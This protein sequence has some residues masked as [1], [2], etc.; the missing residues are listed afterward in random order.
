MS[1]TLQQYNPLSHLG[2][3]LYQDSVA[4]RDARL[5]RETE[6]ARQQAATD[7]LARQRQI[8][9]VDPALRVQ[10]LQR[11]AQVARG[12]PQYEGLFE[13]EVV[14]GA[15]RGLGQMLTPATQRAMAGLPGG[16]AAV[17]AEQAPLI[18]RGQQAAQYQ[19]GVSN[20]RMIT[21]QVSHLIR[22]LSGLTGA[23]GT[24]ASTLTEVISGIKGIDSKRLGE[25]INSP[26][27]R[28]LDLMLEQLNHVASTLRQSLP[29][30]VQAFPELPTSAES[31]EKV[32]SAIRQLE[33]LV[34]VSAKY[35]DLVRRAQDMARED[36]AE[37]GPDDYEDIF[38]AA[39]ED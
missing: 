22:Q 25:I 16:E 9:A 34:K 23:A 15:P 36:G 5:Q 10:G 11:P 37:L 24:G 21:P 33:R 4:E 31:P 27:R 3:L 38:V 20:L 26:E 1:Y 30:G 18:Q 35:S 12:I 14:T 17:A 7:A 13:E 6:F 29:G 19:A 28:E 32:K 8:E 2:Q 39:F